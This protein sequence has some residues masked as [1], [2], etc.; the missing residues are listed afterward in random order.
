[1]G[2]WLGAMISGAMA[3]IFCRY[4]G[5]FWRKGIMISA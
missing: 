2:P 3:S 4:V 1:M 5:Y